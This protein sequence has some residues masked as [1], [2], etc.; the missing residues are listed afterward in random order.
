LDIELI[1]KVCGQK[2]LIFTI[3]EGILNAGFG[4]AVSQQLNRPVEYI[5]LPFEFIPHGSRALLLEKYKLN[6]AGI[7][8]GIRQAIK[9][10]G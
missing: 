5:G 4:S 9:K 2:K 6:A 7:A 1:K 3:E 8:A 10:N